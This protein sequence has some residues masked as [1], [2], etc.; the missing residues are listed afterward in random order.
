MIFLLFCGCFGLLFLLLLGADL[1]L[2]LSVSGK[3]FDLVL[4]SH[5]GKENFKF[6]L[7]N[8]STA[9][10]FIVADFFE[11]IGYILGFKVKILC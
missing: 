6:A 2:A 10:L 4:F 11:Q 3:T 1:Y 8:G 7:I 5:I 9:I